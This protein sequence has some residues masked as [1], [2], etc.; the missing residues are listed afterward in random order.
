MTRKERRRP[1]AAVERYSSVSSDEAESSAGIRMLHPSRMRLG[2][3]NLWLRSKLARYGLG[4]F[5]VMPDSLSQPL[6]KQLL[7]AKAKGT[8]EKKCV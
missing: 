1:S 5:N 8:L 3:R 7:I 2:R 4:N 6:G